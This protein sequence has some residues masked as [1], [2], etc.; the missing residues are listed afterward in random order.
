VL[1]GKAPIETDYAMHAVRQHTL[2]LV[3]V[4]FVVLKFG[5]RFSIAQRWSKLGLPA[6]SKL[7]YFII[8]GLIQQRE[9]K[10]E[11]KQT[12]SVNHS[13]LSNVYKDHFKP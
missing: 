2:V 1:K 7:R 4:F 8:S 3:H 13:H 10:R 12:V 11:M 6:L 5:W 9:T